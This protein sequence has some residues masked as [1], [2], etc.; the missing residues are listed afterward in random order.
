[1]KFSRS[2]LDHSPT[3]IAAVELLWINLQVGYCWLWSLIILLTH[4]YYFS[5]VWIPI[6][7]R[8][9]GGD[10]APP[11]NVTRGSTGFFP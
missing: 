7:D 6:P 2:K 3:N 11:I 4:R 10:L 5:H 1:M 8:V 9:L